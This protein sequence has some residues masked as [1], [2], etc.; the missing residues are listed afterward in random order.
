M[1]GGEKGRGAGV[2][3]DFKHPHPQRRGGKFWHCVWIPVLEK[4]GRLLKEEQDEV[5]SLS[6]GLAPELGMEALPGDL[7]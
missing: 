3:G 5:F 4:G 7:D 2:Q 6:L 1:G